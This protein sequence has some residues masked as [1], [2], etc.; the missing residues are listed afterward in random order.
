MKARQRKAGREEDLQSGG[1]K[2]RR[3][4]GGIAVRMNEGRQAGGKKPGQRGGRKEGWWKEGKPKELRQE[5]G[6][7]V[8]KSGC[9]A[10]RPDR[11][12]KQ[13]GLA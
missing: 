13:L 1:R 9:F 6:K 7:A 2:A 3:Q 5:E 4:A 8:T 11:Q 12:T 10:D